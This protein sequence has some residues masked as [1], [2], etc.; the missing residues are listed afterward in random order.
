MEEIKINNFDELLQDVADKFN[1]G[2]VSDFLAYHVVKKFNE[3]YRYI[4]YIPKCEKYISADESFNVYINVYS[5]SNIETYI[6][7]MILSPYFTFKPSCSSVDLYYTTKK[8]FENVKEE[9][10]GIME[11]LRPRE[12]AQNILEKELKEIALTHKKNK[13]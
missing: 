4:K 11:A 12:D 5:L 7:H 8:E 13:E 6:N 9:L 1:N 3:F 10:F 2:V